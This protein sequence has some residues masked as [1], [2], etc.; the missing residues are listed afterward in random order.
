[1]PDAAATTG[2]VTRFFDRCAVYHDVRGP[3][4][5]L[6]VIWT[7]IAGLGYFFGS[8]GLGVV[9]GGTAVIA[10]L[11]TCAAWRRAG[12]AVNQP[13][14]AAVPGLMALGALVGNRAAG[15]ATIVGAAALV[16]FPDR[17]PF[18]EITGAFTSPADEIDPD[19]EEAQQ[20]TGARL[21][22]LVTDYE[23]GMS[24]RLRRTG[25]VLGAALF[26]GLCV[27]SVIQLERLDSVAFLYLLLALSLYDAGDFLCGADF[28]TRIAGPVAGLIAVAGITGVLY[29]V[30]PP[31][32]IGTEVI[33]AGA[34]IG[35]GAVLG[36]WLGSW[37]LPS[38]RS[39]APGLRR[40]DSW[41]IAT[42]ALV[43]W[44]WV[45]GR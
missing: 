16:L 1:V 7:G 15:V 24:A 41:L 43:A 17:L 22:A 10:S 14:A 20:S 26:P 38:P 5:R 32:L 31:V 44:L 3:R 4:I 13:I 19:S 25:P 33:V 36:Q 29:V 39:R 6:A 18:Q 2:S 34:L 30:E 37:L 35:V 45:L 27:V 8:L 12:A 23:G 21:V 40:L 42:P 11:Q 28:P 9:F